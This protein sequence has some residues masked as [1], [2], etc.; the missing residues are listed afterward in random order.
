M[1]QALRVALWVPT[2]AP[3]DVGDGIVTKDVELAAKVLPT[4]FVLGGG[5]GGGG[6]IPEAPVNGK[7]FGR[8]DAG[9]IEITTGGSGGGIAE[10]PV[11]GKPYV[12]Q[13]SGWVAFDII[14]AGTF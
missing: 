4:R 12:R 1:T 14:D 7:T 9:W 8:K 10:A 3:P 11:D 5:G 2:D 6:G 13:S